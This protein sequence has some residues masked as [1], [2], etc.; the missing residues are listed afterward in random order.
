MV[1]D[2]PS[3]PQDRAPAGPGEV[4][5]GRHDRVVS[6]GLRGLSV[7]HGEAGIGAAG[8]GGS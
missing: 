7:A 1:S 3:T 6:G 8:W 2:D 4:T 5:V